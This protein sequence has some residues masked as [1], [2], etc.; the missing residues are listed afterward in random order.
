[1]SGWRQ[2]MTTE[3]SWGSASPSVPAYANSLMYSVESTLW[4]ARTLL[5]PGLTTRN[6]K[7][8]GAPG[9]ATRSKDATNVAR[10]PEERRTAH[11]GKSKTSK[12]R[13]CKRK[14]RISLTRA[15]KRTLY[16][17]GLRPTFSDQIFEAFVKTFILSPHKSIIKLLMS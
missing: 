7:L 13:D 9:I 17:K 6:K 14:V 1:M 16:V 11:L 5:G 3:R 10:G 2:W 8:L 4:G 15:F 12:R